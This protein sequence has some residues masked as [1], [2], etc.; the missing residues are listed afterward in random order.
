M[1]IA[2]KNHCEQYHRWTNLEGKIR[3]DVVKGCRLLIMPWCN[4]SSSVKEHGSKTLIANHSNH[5]QTELAPFPR[6]KNL[7]LKK[8]KYTRRGSTSS[9]SPYIYRMNRFWAYY[10]SKCR[11]YPLVQRQPRP[12]VV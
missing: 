10:N 1:R 4:A 5:T 2:A 3:S 6:T 9:C 11:D 7:R 8:I 12:L